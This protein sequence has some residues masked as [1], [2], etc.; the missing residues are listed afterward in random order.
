MS[1][2]DE[3]IETNEFWRAQS[4]VALA[5]WTRLIMTYLGQIQKFSWII[6]LIR[7]SC[8]STVVFLS[9]FILGV[10]AFA[11]SFNALE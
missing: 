5:I 10:T 2:D 8:S 9:V 4:W 7:H 11:D 3:V 1:S 6:G